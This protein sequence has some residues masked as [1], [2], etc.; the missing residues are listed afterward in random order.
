MITRA[1]CGVGIEAGD[2]QLNVGFNQI[3][4][5]F[6]LDG[7]LAPPL[8]AAVTMGYENVVVTSAQTDGN[9]KLASAYMSCHICRL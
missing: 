2:A 1:Y 4:L 9:A 7:R 8:L 3:S 5:C 6:W